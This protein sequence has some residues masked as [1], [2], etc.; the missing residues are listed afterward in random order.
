MFIVKIVHNLA[1]VHKIARV[2]NLARVHK[3][4]RVLKL[5]RVPSRQNLNLNLNSLLYILK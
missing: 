5:A 3:I 2:H 4:A 1:R